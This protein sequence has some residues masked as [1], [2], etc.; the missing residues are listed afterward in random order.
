[1]PGRKPQHMYELI[2]ADEEEGGKEEAVFEF[3]P[4]GY[5]MQD[6]PQILAAAGKAGARWVVVEQDNPS[7]GKTSLECARMS[8]DYLNSLQ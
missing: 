8:I 6:F 2:G 4:V 5:G 1:M 7:L 3:R